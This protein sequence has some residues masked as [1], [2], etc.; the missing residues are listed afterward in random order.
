MRNGPSKGLEWPWL[1]EE[2]AHL[3]DVAKRMKSRSQTWRTRHAELLEWIDANTD[4][5]SVREKSQGRARLNR[6]TW[7]GKK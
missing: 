3:E 7:G 2:I 4:L 5:L 1:D 6:L